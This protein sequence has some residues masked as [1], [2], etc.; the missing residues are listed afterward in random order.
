MAY[1]PAPNNISIRTQKQQTTAHGGSSQNSVKGRDH[2][3]QKYYIRPRFG[4]S[5]R[6]AHLAGSGHSAP[7]G[8]AGEA[9]AEQSG[10]H[11]SLLKLKFNKFP[12]LVKNTLRDLCERPGLLLCFSLCC[13]VIGRPRF[14]CHQAPALPPQIRLAGTLWSCGR[15]MAA[16]KQS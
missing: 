5:R 16:P 1:H 11:F 13:A 10:S 7:E 9:V 4:N 8:G 14:P 15:C 2:K 6:R 3:E 12:S